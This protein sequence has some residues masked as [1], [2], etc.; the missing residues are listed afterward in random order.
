MVS[1]NRKGVFVGPIRSSPAY[2]GLMIVGTVLVVTGLRNVSIADFL[3]SV[4]KLGP[5]PKPGTGLSEAESKA[6]TESSRVQEGG[7]VLGLPAAGSATGRAVAEAALSYV[8]KVPYK[9]AGETPAG[10]DCSGMVSYILHTQFGIELPDDTHTVT[11]QFYVWSGAATVA[12]SEAAP[13]DLACWV[14]HIGICIDSGHMVNAALP[15]TMTRI[16]PLTA[17][18]PPVIRRPLAYGAPAQ[19]APATEKAAA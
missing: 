14:G 15:G 12:N 13:G 3:R 11:S 18:V 10:W 4:V 16:D 6:A 19:A 1:V 9:W 5:L 7:G 8:G 17:A 2:L